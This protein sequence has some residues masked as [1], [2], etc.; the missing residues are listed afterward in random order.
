M[1][2]LKILILIISLHVVVSA[3]VISINNIIDE[4]KKQDKQVLIFFH[5]T[6]CGA[7]KKMIKNS[8]ND[9]EITKQINR[10]FILVDLN[11]NDND[12]VIHNDFE[13][14]IHRYAKSLNINFYPSNIFIDRDN[15]V[16]FNLKGYR[17]K[18][19]FSTVIEYISTKAY[20]KMSLESFIDEKDFNE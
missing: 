13:G 14:S 12:S 18:E 17:D 5:M 7:C 8:F 4:A 11:I 3:K 9:Q 1:N 6:Y 19:K 20:K 16:I 10:D 2:P 15:E